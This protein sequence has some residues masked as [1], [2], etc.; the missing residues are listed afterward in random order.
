[1]LNKIN[2][3]P[4][5]VLDICVSK[6]CT[7]VEVYEEIKEK[8]IEFCTEKYSKFAALEYESHLD[9]LEQKEHG[10]YTLLR[11]IGNVNPSDKV[12]LKISEQLDDV[13]TVFG[14]FDKKSNIEFSHIWKGYGGYRIPVD[15]SITNNKIYYGDRVISNK[16][17]FPTK[18]L[19][20]NNG[21]ITYIYLEGDSFSRAMKIEDLPGL[22][23]LAPRQKTRFANF[24]QDVVY[25]NTR[26][27]NNNKIKKQNF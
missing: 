11:Y 16:V 3:V 19:H 7:G 10:I 9:F 25:F 27:P 22:P 4:K 24:I 6:E 15:Y 5:C 17:I 14:L 12:V 21:E 18:L 2:Y 13:E 26:V 23:F 1:M 8:S 20:I